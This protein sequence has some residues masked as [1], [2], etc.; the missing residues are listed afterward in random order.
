MC[1]VLLQLVHV[2]L[3]A[4]SEDRTARFSTL[5]QPFLLFA[6]LDLL[7]AVQTRDISAGYVPPFR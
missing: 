1:V 2:V 5:S 3:Q 6:F 7:G 4:I